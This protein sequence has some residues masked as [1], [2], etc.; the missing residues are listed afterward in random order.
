MQTHPH[1]MLRG[2]KLGIVTG[3]T[4]HHKVMILDP[5]RSSLIIDRFVGIPHQCFVCVLGTL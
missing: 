1:V 2:V 3:L 5:N 4:G